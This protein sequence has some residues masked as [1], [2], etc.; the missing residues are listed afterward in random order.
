M[1]YTG[2]DTRW[3]VGVRAGVKVG[4][5]GECNETRLFKIIFKCVFVTYQCVIRVLYV[6]TTKVGD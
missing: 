3:Q 2:I 1:V 6:Y 4:V 5:I